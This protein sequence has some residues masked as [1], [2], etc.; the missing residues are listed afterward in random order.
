MTSATTLLVTGGARVSRDVDPSS[1]PLIERA[2]IRGDMWGARAAVP[3]GPRPGQPDNIVCGDYFECFSPTDQDVMIAVWRSRGYTHVVMGPIV[4]AGYHGQ[5][6]SVDWRT[7]F[8]VY[9]DAAQKLET[10]GFR[11]VHFIRPDRG[12]AGLEW[13]VDDLERELAP[14][15]RTPRAQRLMAIVVL[16]WEPGERYYYDNAWWVAMVQWLARTFPRALRCIHMV[17]DCD[18]PTGGNDDRIV[19]PDGSR[20]TNAEAWRRVAPS[21][22]LFLDQVA[23]Y[24]Q[25][26]DGTTWDRGDRAFPAHLAQFKRDL[27]D[28]AADFQARFQRGKADWPTFSAWGP[29][30][31]ILYIYAEGA[32]FVEYWLNWPEDE[33][34]VLGDVA[35]GGGAAGYLNGGTVDVPP[36]W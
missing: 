21:I 30:R 14:L 31:G 10:A 15:F 7:D 2:R 34:R 33:A 9:L 8:H 19:L 26:P 23:G 4:D 35:M 11:V 36:V 1:I 6:P 16:G 12:V 25:K 17:S 18:A 29:D 22:H 27:A 24:F 20:F 3:W 5:L 28:R 32:A 13:T